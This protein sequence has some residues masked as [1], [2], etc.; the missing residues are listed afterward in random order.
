GNTSARNSGVPAPIWREVLPPPSGP[1]SMTLVD[2]PATMAWPSLNVRS[3]SRIM[4]FSSNHVGF[5][6][7]Q[8]VDGADR[9][10]AE[11]GHDLAGLL[12]YPQTYVLQVQRGNVDV[13]GCGAVHVER[14]ATTAQVGHAVQ[15]ADH[16]VI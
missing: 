9:H 6:V 8:S 10:F 11:R 5:G 12:P 1:R 7:E 15:G 3:A 14:S 16:G 13:F 4:V 2:G